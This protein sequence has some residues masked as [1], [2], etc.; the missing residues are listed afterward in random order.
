M[1]TPAAVCYANIVLFYVESPILHQLEPLYYRRYIDDLFV[2]FPKELNAAS[3]VT[4]FNSRCPSIQLDAIT[5]GTH[6][7]FLDM[8]I[9]LASS[10]IVFRLYQK[11]SNKYL[12]LPPTTSH[13][14]H[15]LVNI[16]RQER[17]RFRLLNSLD[18]DF[19]QADKLYFNRL[20][21]R[22][23]NKT[24][25]IPLFTEYLARDSLIGALAS[26]RTGIM[27]RSSGPVI[28]LSLPKLV[29]AA[30][31]YR[32]LQ[33]PE[34]LTT[35]ARF[36]HIY[37]RNILFG[38]KLGKSIGRRLIFRPFTYPPSHLQHLTE[39]GDAGDEPSL[40]LVNPNSNP[41]DL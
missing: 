19:Q 4:L 33:L 14:R 35:H 18:Y 8:D 27:R 24:F 12:Y 16:V 17:K 39:D 1:G 31:L 7:I 13:S 28:T 36:K 2:I 9:T 25:L 23:Y 5:I 41:A 6:G 30:P 34:S 40:T 10:G 11:A 38:S 22:G 3:A 20:L 32:S 21:A 15:V 26:R 37:R 29:N